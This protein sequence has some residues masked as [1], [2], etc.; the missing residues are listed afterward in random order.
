MKHNLYN[1]FRVPCSS[2]SYAATWDGNL[3]FL[4]CA[5]KKVEKPRRKGETC[6]V[7]RQIFRRIDEDIFVHTPEHENALYNFMQDLSYAGWGRMFAGDTTLWSVSRAFLQDD[8][9][10]LHHVSVAL[11]FKWKWYLKSVTLTHFS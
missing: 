5:K 4:L 1:D 6:Y 2:F 9:V 11:R 10:E 3:V 7:K 8:S